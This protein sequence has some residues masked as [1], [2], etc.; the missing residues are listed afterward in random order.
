MYDFAVSPSVYATALS[1]YFLLTEIAKIETALL[2]TY[3]GFISS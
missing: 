1:C 3:N 2:M